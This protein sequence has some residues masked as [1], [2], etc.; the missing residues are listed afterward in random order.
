MTILDSRSI[1]N[2]SPKVPCKSPKISLKVTFRG[3]E[4]ILKGNTSATYSI[5][6]L[7]IHYCYFITCSRS[8]WPVDMS[9]MS[10]AQ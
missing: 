4:R 7:K 1:G 10:S 2:I 8:V 5:P 3:P 6:H 9:T